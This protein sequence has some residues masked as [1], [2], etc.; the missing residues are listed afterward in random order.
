LKDDKDSQQLLGFF[1]MQ[2]YAL[3]IAIS[4]FYEM[5][6]EQNISTNIRNGNYRRYN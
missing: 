1:S 4:I 5:Y 6:L 2:F 3:H